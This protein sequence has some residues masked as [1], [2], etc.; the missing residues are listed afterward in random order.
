[1]ALFNDCPKWTT[2]DSYMTRKEA[3]ADISQYIPNN[4]YIWEAFYGDGRSGKYL[5]ELGFQVYHEDI[6]FFESNPSGTTHIISNPP[7]TQKREVFERLKLLGKPFI[8]LVPTTVLHTKYFKETFQDEHIQLIIPFRK[9]QFDK[10]E[11]GKIVE[12]KDNCS[13]YTLYVCWR[14]NLD[15]DIILI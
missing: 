12:Q 10:L 6:D 14:M 9:R 3:W 8:M 4:A 15:K 1:M 11:G 2:H 7:Y 5:E 13:F